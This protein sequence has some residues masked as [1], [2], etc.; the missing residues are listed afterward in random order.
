MRRAATGVLLSCLLLGC[1]PRKPA[2]EEPTIV[3]DTPP[4]RIES[5]LHS[6]AM[7][8]AVG[9]A[10]SLP[11]ILIRV[12]FSSQAPFANWDAL[13]EEACE[14]MSLIM[15]EHFLEGTDLTPDDAEIQL[16]S[17]VAWER[18][19]GYGEDVT[20]AELG[21][22]ARTLYR[23]RTRVLTDV[24]E[25]SLKAELAA[26]HPVIV[27]AAGRLLRNPFFSGDGPYYHML[28][29][30]GYTGEGFITNDPGTKRGEQY[31]YPTSVLL[32]AIHDWVG[33]KERIAEGPKRALVVE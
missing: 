18:D 15:V 14:E 31:F 2:F 30:V 22:I 3:I 11:G 7:S 25:E 16:Q 24:T 27:P 8:A 19:H 23:S 13:H 12:P 29:I 26:R 17:L 1:S 21:E 6:S 10:P 28:V 33:V 32:G 5:A 9:S 4:V 20:I